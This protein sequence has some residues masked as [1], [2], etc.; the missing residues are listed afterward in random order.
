[1]DLF[2]FDGL[3]FDYKNLL[4]TVILILS[5]FISR[6]IL[7]RIVRRWSFRD[8]DDRRKRIVG[9]KNVLTLVLLLG[10]VF[11]WGSELRAFALSI[12]AALAALVIAT[13]ELILCVMGGM[14]KYSTKLFEVGDRIQIAGLRGK[15]TDHNFL[16]TSL[17]EIGPGQKSNQFTGRIL[18]IP[19]SLYLTESVILESKDDEY[20]LMVFKIPLPMTHQIGRV[21]MLLQDV[22]RV[23][24]QPYFEKAKNQLQR[25]FMREGVAIPQMEPKVF[26]EILD[27]ESLEFH[28]RMLVPFEKKSTV[29]KDL[30]ENFFNEY[31][32]IY[33]ELE[34]PALSKV[35]E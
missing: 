27:T 23:V 20:N 18:K 10:L 9:F 31:G 32:K 35:L 11:I 12:V 7:L 4:S 19:N 14:L 1:M 16:V 21:E 13:K 3:Q 25:K 6:S 26:Y 24:C 34:I 29:E 28:I 30:I 5:F 8:A 2:N 17:L 15:V 22:A 33:T